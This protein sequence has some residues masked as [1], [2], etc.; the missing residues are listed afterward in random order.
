MQLKNK[1]QREAFLNT[2]RNWKLL[3]EAPE[4]ELKFYKYIIVETG[5]VII[6]TEYPSF[7]IDTYNGGKIKYK[8]STS[9]K[10]HLLLD[11]GDKYRGDSYFEREYR[12][13]NPSGHSIS[14]IVDYLLRTKPEI[15]DCF[16]Q[17]ICG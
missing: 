12:A 7:E 8:K 13:Y 16:K 1:K 3:Y 6:A 4:L 14:T 9:V 2:Y 15:E 11:E 17:D 10:Y 5:A